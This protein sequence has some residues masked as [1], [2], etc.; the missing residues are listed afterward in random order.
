MSVSPLCLK[1]EERIL[2]AGLVAYAMPIAGSIPKRRQLT[3]T[4][5]ISYQNI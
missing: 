1:M 4:P 3:R 5:E 2:S